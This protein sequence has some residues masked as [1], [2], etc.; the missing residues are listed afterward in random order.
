MCLA[1][2]E[3]LTERKQMRELLDD[4]ADEMDEAS[5]SVFT[6]HELEGM[7][8]AGIAVSSAFLRHGGVSAAPRARALPAARAGDRARLDLGTEGAKR[9]DGPTLLRQTQWSALGRALLDVGAFT[10]KPATTRARTLAALGV[11]AAARH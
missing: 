8:R 9:I 7:S 5:R 4:I 11:R 1:T 10:P 3:D 2:P 6:L